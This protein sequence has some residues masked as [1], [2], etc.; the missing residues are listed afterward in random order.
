MATLG[1]TRLL[2]GVRLEFLARAS[3]AE[4]GRDS[5]PG[6]G[7]GG[8]PAQLRERH[9]RSRTRR[10]ASS[11][12]RSGAAT[13][14]T[15]GKPIAGVATSRRASWYARCRCRPPSP[16]PNALFDCRYLSDRGARSWHSSS[17]L[18]EVVAEGKVGGVEVERHRPVTREVL[19]LVDLDERVA[20]Q[21]AR[22]RP[23]ATSAAWR[24]GRQ[25]RRR[26]HG[27]SGPRSRAPRRAPP[28][29][30]RWPLWLSHG[31]RARSRTIPSA[32]A[33]AA[34]ARSQSPTGIPT[35]LRGHWVE[36]SAQGPYAPTALAIRDDR[37]A[38][39]VRQ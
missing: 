18:V 32:A 22:S 29:R 5:A 37:A 7:P 10:Y 34:K 2:P 38:P 19:G 8:D 9:R 6:G 39:S 31:T 1:G 27:R 14:T 26:V 16:K 21:G 11:P 4:T 28:G 3:V 15:G 13:R 25:G 23:A 30:P 33:A 24:S 36:E 17:V 12:S 35:K 20:S